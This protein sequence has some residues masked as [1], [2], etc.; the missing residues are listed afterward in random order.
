MVA[1]TYS[2]STWRVRQENCHKWEASLGCKI[3][4]L[5]GLQSKTLFQNKPKDSVFQ[6]NNTI[7]QKTEIEKN[8]SDIV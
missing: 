3:L 2:F 5:L 7:T 8:N 4:S 1:H 6:T